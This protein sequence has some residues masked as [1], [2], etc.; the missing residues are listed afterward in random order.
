MVKGALRSLILVLALV[1]FAP[2]ALADMSADQLKS[3]RE[4]LS[5]VEE[6]K[7]LDSQI[8]KLNPIAGGFHSKVSIFGLFDV[9]LY[10]YFPDGGARP[11]VAALTLPSIAFSTI[12]PP[13]KGTP[14]DVTVDNPLVLAA[15]KGYL[16]LDK[17]PAG[18]AERARATGFTSAFHVDT[19]LNMFGKV[20]GHDDLLHQVLRV[21]NLDGPLLA[22]YVSPSGKKVEDPNDPDKEK[23]LKDR[24]LY[25]ALTDGNPW[26]E[27]FF[28]K[29][30]AIERVS[31]QL[32]RSKDRELDPQTLIRVNG[33]AKIGS[34]VP[35]YYH[36]FVEKT[37]DKTAADPKSLAMVVAVNPNTSVNLGDFVSLGEAFGATLGLPVDWLDNA[38]KLPLAEIKLRNPHPANEAF[39]EAGDYPDFAKVLFA[40][41][42][43]PAKIPGRGALTG[44]GPLLTVNADATVFGLDAAGLEGTISLK[45]GLKVDAKVKAPKL[46]PITLAKADLDVAAG[47]TAAHMKLHAEAAG[48]GKI[49]V[50]ADGSGLRF[51]VPAQCPLRPVGLVASLKGFNLADDFSVTPQMKDCLAPVFDELAKDGEKAVK[52]AADVAGEAAD[53]A[54]GLA[55]EAEGVIAGLAAKRDELWRKAFANKVNA[56]KALSEATAAVGGLQEAVNKLDGTIASLGRDIE[57]GLRKLWGAI[58][59]ALKKKKKE[60]QNQ[61]S[62]RD[63]KRT[64][65]AAA[66][67]RE[68]QAAKAAAEATVPYHDDALRQAQAEELGKLAV[69]TQ[70]TRFAE[71]ARMVPDF[72]KSPEARKEIFDADA[73]AAQAEADFTAEHGSTLRSI[74]ASFGSLDAATQAPVPGGE[75]VAALA[76]GKRLDAARE[77]ILREE[78]PRLPTMAFGKK[79]LMQTVVQ[80]QVRCLTS[81][82]NSPNIDT[83]NSPNVELRDCQGGGDQVFIFRDSGQVSAPDAVVKRTSSSPWGPQTATVTS[84]CLVHIGGGAPGLWYCST[85]SDSLYFFDP[86]DGVIRNSMTYQGGKNCLL[87]QPAPVIAPCPQGDAAKTVWRLVDAEQFKKGEPV[88]RATRRVAGPFRA[89]AP[90]AVPGGTVETNL[91]PLALD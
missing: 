31:L 76:V 91:A 10:V 39:P 28:L 58:T 14:M 54:T 24:V 11:P 29:H 4:M 63:T 15:V 47:A 55:K 50:E 65:L 51:A 40:G 87:A 75:A 22:G 27:P 30:T 42:N 19:G 52:L 81:T 5:G 83:G 57:K 1:G 77:K 89:A 44:Q 3:L 33:L 49:E 56:G 23:K 38:R 48:V 68:Q 80:N 21:I 73:V 66:K 34:G 86:L 59:G 12:I 37:F 46:G 85:D 72:L 8:A 60:R 67:Q 9:S 61:I 78:V 90:A 17:M 36:L 71:A 88:A 74:L 53:E 69:A 79:V 7:G 41:A 20:A 13:L 82:G 45:D 64:E 18:L 2:A 84:P 32:R 25:L 6:L 26:K 70:Q 62:D 35:K 16:H 43:P